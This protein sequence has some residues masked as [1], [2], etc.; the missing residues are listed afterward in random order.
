MRDEPL[1]EY[2]ARI[3]PEPSDN[4]RESLG[5]LLVTTAIVVM[6]ALYLGAVTIPGWIAA[7]RGL[8]EMAY[9]FGHNP[10]SVMM[11]AWAALFVAYPTTIALAFIRN[12][13]YSSLMMVLFCIVF[14]TLI[15]WAFACMFLCG[16]FGDK[17]FT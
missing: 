7:H 8:P 14:V 6:I 4:H 15:A 2:L 16:A 10:M 12:Q 11:I 9:L 13:I 5:V 1:K 17:C 3:K